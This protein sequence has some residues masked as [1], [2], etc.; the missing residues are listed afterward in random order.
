M[1]KHTPASRTVSPLLLSLLALGSAAHAQVTLSGTNGV[2]VKTPGGTSITEFANT[3]AVKI[4]G[5]AP[6]GYVKSDASGV[7]SVDGGVAGP[8]GP[9]GPA[10]PAGATGAIGPAGPAGATGATGTTGAQG[11]Q[12]PAGATGAQGIQGPAGTAG[13]SA[14]RILGS[15]VAD[16]TNNTYY[17]GTAGNETNLAHAIDSPLAGTLKNLRV[18]I[19]AAS[20]SGNNRIFTVMNGATATTITCTISGNTATTCQS[21]GTATVAVG[22]L[23]TLRA[24]PNSNPTNTIVTWSLLIE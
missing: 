10:G 5:L 6:G 20:G 7:L 2:A 14:V 23:I 9:T 1:K 21:A 24:V 15:S 19:A 16:L 8:A 18:R 22:D 4:P 12:G 11:I 13:S 3:G 17:V